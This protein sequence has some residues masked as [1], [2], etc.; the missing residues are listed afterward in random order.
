MYIDYILILLLLNMSIDTFD[1]KN[2][3]RY[4]LSIHLI[5]RGNRSLITFKRSFL[6]NFAHKYPQDI[7]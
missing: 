6:L 3:N 1:W 4:P 7:F 2:L 5:P